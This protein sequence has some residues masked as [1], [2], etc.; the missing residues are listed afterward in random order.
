MVIFTTA[1]WIKPIPKEQQKKFSTL[2]FI[3]GT[4]EKFKSAI[5]PSSSLTG[6]VSSNTSRKEI[7]PKRSKQSSSQFY[8]DIPRDI[9]DSCDNTNNDKMDRSKK[10]T[11]NAMNHDSDEFKQSIENREKSIERRIANTNTVC[12]QTQPQGG[13]LKNKHKDQIKSTSSAMSKG[14]EI[15]VIDNKDI[16]ESIRNEPSVLVY[17]EPINVDLC[18]QLGY[19][20]PL[21]AGDAAIL[22]NKSKLQSTN[23]TQKHSS[24]NTNCGST[25]DNIPIYNKNNRSKSSNLLSHLGTNLNKKSNDSISF[26][27]KNTDNKKM[28]RKSI[29]Y[30]ITLTLDH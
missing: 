3:S 16:D 11:A 22:L 20:W 27:N 30:F 15:V 25:N 4:I 5:G 10:E 21:S 6:S 14:P 29:F 18:N 13:I 8:D 26:T 9:T 28:Q 7:K 17:E 24:V 12:T 19:D 23:A 2:E 1:N